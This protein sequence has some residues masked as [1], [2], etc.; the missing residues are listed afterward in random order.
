[1]FIK[2]VYRKN[3]IYPLLFILS[4]F[5]RI[6]VKAFFNLE[7]IVKIKITFLT[8]VMIYLIQLIMGL[9]ILLYRKIINKSKKEV[10]IRGIKLIQN[11]GLKRPDSGIKILILIFFSAFFEIIGFLT[12]RYFTQ[13]LSDDRYDEYHAKFRSIEIIFASILCYFTFHIKMHKHQFLSLFIICL[14]LII[15]LIIDIVSEDDFI[16]N[17]SNIMISSLCRAYLD[18]TEK[19]LFDYNY[20]DV[21]EI[22]GYEAIVNCILTPILYISDK[23]RK[24][25]RD[26][27]ASDNSII[28]LIF[29]LLLLYSLFTLFKNIYRRLTIRVYDPMTRALAESIL[30]PIFI[31]YDFFF[32]KQSYQ[33]TLSFIVTLSCII[34]N[35]ICSCIYNEILILYCFDLEYQTHYEISSRSE[36][37]E[38]QMNERNSEG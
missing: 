15:V 24:E 1:M 25:I 32:N 6:V 35:I 3:L 30:D 7:S 8:L 33:S 10:Q 38:L 22:M 21:F 20:I 28:V 11:K 19:Y 37:V 17:L 14:S 29:I 26:I 13:N 9:F 23:P 31:I 4:L 34:I 5:L 2:F 36:S 12:R 18:T 16:G 27:F